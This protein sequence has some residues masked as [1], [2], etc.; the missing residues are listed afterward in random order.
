MRMCAARCLFC[1]RTLRSP[2]TIIA[3]QL[4]LNWRK[5]TKGKMGMWCNQNQR[6]WRPTS[7]C[8]LL[9]ESARKCLEWEPSED[10]DSQD[11]TGWSDNENASQHVKV[12]LRPEA[13]T[14]GWLSTSGK[15]TREICCFEKATSEQDR[16][17]VCRRQ[18]SAD[19][20][21]PGRERG[22]LWLVFVCLQLQG[23]GLESHK[24]I[25]R[26]HVWACL[27][28]GAQ[29]WYKRLLTFLK[30]IEQNNNKNNEP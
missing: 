4:K 22:Q 8:L 14:E 18:A 17:D 9:L 21:T 30:E 15:W 20:N 10:V 29:L 27:V 23:C 28:V 13:R 3:L 24:L 19:W 1:W 6:L 5:I 7:K 11:A 2:S 16:G 26:K 25:P 12:T